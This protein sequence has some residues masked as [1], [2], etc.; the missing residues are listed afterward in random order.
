MGGRGWFRPAPPPHPIVPPYGRCVADRNDL[1]PFLVELGV[2]MIKSSQTV[3]DV[4]HQ[5]IDIAS[6][7]GVDDLEVIALPTAIMLESPASA[8]DDTTSVRSRLR[9][10][11]GQGFRLDQV[12]AVDALARRARMGLVDA[13][14]GLDELAEITMR[15]PPHRRIVRSLGL[16]VLATGFSLALQPSLVGVLLA[17][18]LGTV[19]GA[20]VTLE[21]PGFGPVTPTITSFVVSLLVFALYD[22]YDGQ[23]PIRLLIPP[24]LIFLPGAKLTLGTIELAEGAIVSGTSRLMSGL[25][26]LLLLATAIVAAASLIDLP[27]TDLLDRPA[28][29]LGAWSLIPAVVLIA[30]GYRY[31]SCATRRSVP[32]ILL[33]LSV[34]LATERLASLAFSPAVSAFVAAAVM[35]PV[36]LAIDRRP[37]GPRAMVLFLPGFYLLVPGATGLIDVTQSVAP[38]F[39]SSSLLNTM[40]IVVAIALGVLVAKGGEEAAVSLADARRHR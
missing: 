40:L 13:Q 37:A 25:I 14:Q 27:E 4:E 38:V 35:T 39:T 31:F 2:S 34:A 3:D 9:S 10:V 28:P 23:N 30:F 1:D 17:F 6:V 15:P 36:V 22:F 32:W 16:G 21:L 5:L 7:M 26:D 11:R 18:A 12:Q 8:T 33:V 20:F 29:Q 19:V 24:L